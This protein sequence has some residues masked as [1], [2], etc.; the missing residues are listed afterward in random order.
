MPTTLRR[1]KRCLTPPAV[2]FVLVLVASFAP[3]AAHENL[4]ANPGFESVSGDF[5][6]GWNHARTAGIGT[7]LFVDETGGNGRCL[8][9][10]GTPG[11]WTT[12]PG[13][14]IMVEP[15]TEYWISWSF[16][17][18]QPAT[19]RTYLFLQTNVAQRVFPHTDRRGDFDWTRSVVKYRT[20][21][22]ET[23]LYP[24]LT[25]QT[26]HEPPG[27]SWWDDVGVWRTLPP[28]LETE[29][30]R[31]HP[32]DDV[33]VPTAQ[34]H[35]AT[36]AAVIWGDCGE[37]RIYPTT[38]PPGGAP[39]T[40]IALTAPGRGHAVYQLVATPEHPMEPVALRFAQ[41]TGPGAM[42]IESLRY[43]IVRGVPVQRVRD[44]SFP[45]GATPDPLVEPDGA[46]PVRVG[47]NTVFWIEWAPPV[48][49]KPGTY[50]SHIEVHSGSHRVATIPLDLHRWGFDL[51]EVP[52]FRSM[53][54]V[55][56][57]PIRQFHPDLSEDQAYRLAWDPLAAHRLSGFNIAV[58]PSVRLKDG[59]LEIDWTRFDRLVAAAKQY[60][61]SAITLGPM[62][63]GGAGQGWKP[64]PF[65]GLTPLDDPQF[66]S[67]YIE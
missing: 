57:S 45:L 37:A 22:G 11:T 29:Y 53:V 3:A 58:W 6:T 12:C 26:A 4:L 62:F 16:Q 32:W 60:R 39:T 66:E 64:H 49:S 24:V 5:F 51:P 31:Q 61:A 52:H 19:S 14:P 8:R 1:C 44:K 40:G 59:G 35:A 13:Q 21:P 65:V 9:M 34:R 67:L 17:A 30:R 54:L 46:E 41:P 38:A 10:I 15:E 25:M 63:G 2:F 43:R 36:A 50:R 23:S 20:A 28:E 48:E 18:R 7:V 56:A 33:D 42:P 55:P 27:T 47:E